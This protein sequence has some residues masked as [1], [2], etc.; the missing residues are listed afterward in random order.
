MRKKIFQNSFSDVT[1]FN[2]IFKPTLMSEIPRQLL[3]SERSPCLRNEFNRNLI[4]FI[5]E[6]T[7]PNYIKN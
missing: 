1:I 5:R 4:P 2:K 6:I 3:Q 7:I